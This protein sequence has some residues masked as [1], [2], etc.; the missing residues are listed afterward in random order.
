MR[1]S[2][3]SEPTSSAFMTKAPVVLTVPPITRAPVSLPTGMGSP[4]MVDSSTEPEP[5]ITVPSTGTFSPGRTRSASPT[6]I[7]S[8]ATSE[9]LPSAPTR[10]AV[11]GA[12]P[13]SALMA[14]PVASRA[15]SS[16][17]WPT[18]TSTTMIDA[19]SK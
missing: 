8:I 11:R 15:R 6:A 10:I 4:V 7:W 16:S 19:G 13:N 14:P 5:S 17:T 18:S 9:S 2:M 3:V 1:A 12:S